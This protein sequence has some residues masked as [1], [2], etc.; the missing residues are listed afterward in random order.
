MVF[1][2][3]QALVCGLEQSLVFELVLLVPTEIAVV[4]KRVNSELGSLEQISS[5]RQSQNCM[6]CT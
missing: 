2:L 5:L 3:E 6:S 4:V 1:G